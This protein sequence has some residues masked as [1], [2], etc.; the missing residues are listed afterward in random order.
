MTSEFPEFTNDQWIPCNKGP[1]MQK[2]FP[3]DDIIMMLFA[4]GYAV[5]T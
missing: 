3:F 4:P 5:D 1:V 2:M